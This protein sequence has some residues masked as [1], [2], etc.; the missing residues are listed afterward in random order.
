MLER[1]A[2]KP[3]EDQHL[4]GVQSGDQRWVHDHSLGG[5]PLDIRRYDGRVGLRQGGRGPA[6]EL[7][8]AQHQLAEI[9]AERKRL[10]EA[11]VDEDEAVPVRRPG[12]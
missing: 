5:Q 8:L 12:R 9:E 7:N 2:R 3:G 10:P 6:T 4:E 1:D 11:E